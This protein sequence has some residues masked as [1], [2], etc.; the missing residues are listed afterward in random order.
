[1]YI[2]PYVFINIFVTLK[3][4]HLYLKIKINNNTIFYIVIQID[5]Y[6]YTLNCL[7]WKKIVSIFIQYYRIEYICLKKKK[8]YINNNN[9]CLEVIRGLDW[10]NMRLCMF[11]YLLLALLLAICIITILYI[12]LVDFRQ[13]I[14]K[15]NFSINSLDI[16]YRYNG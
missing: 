2:K 3:K 10:Y 16:I 7:L 14:N 5:H 6:L 8:Y 12:V 11:Y 9:K 13:R 1:M 4:Q 15:Y